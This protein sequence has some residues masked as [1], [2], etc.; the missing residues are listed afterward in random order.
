MSTIY[1]TGCATVPMASADLDKAK[2]EFP[3]PSEGKS[4]LYV[5]RNSSLGSAYKL[6]VSVDG[7]AIGET[8]ANTYIYKELPPG[9]HEISS[10]STF[11]NKKPSIDFQKGINYFFHQSVIFNSFGDTTLRQVTEDEGKKGV[12]E[13]KLAQ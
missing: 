2:K 11:G 4:G 3:A 10:E 6:T 7:A 12:L 13:T 8:A 1:L 9:T 5:Y